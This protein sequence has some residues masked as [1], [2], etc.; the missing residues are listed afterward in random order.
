MYP[1][2]DIFVK[3]QYFCSTN[4][5]SSLN[6]AKKR[7]IKNPSKAIIGKTGIEIIRAFDFSSSQVVCKYS[8]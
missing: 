5:A 2:I 1:K 6:D 3:N 4:Q 7:F 8:K